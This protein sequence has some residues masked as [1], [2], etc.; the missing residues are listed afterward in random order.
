MPKPAGTLGS[1]KMKILALV[2]ENNDCGKESY[3]YEI[4]K[5][6]KEHFYI[7]LSDNDI[8]NVYNH[9]NDLCKSNHLLRENE[10]PDGRCYYK[11]TDEGLALREKYS[12][13]IGIIENKM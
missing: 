11:M 10:S 3:G 8:G 2:C 9:L 13:Y 1:T 5:E 6:L 4:W 7:F 12:Q